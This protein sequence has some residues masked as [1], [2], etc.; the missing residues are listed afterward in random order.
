MANLV[1]PCKD[2]ESRE[3]LGSPSNHCAF[4]PVILRAALDWGQRNLQL[5]DIPLNLYASGLASII[6][7]VAPIFLL[8]T[9]DAIPV[10]CNFNG[11]KGNLACVHSGN[12][13]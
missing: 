12:L 1:Q 7:F 6:N 5:R 11:I 9:F 4:A 3:A 13:V 8:Y 2:T 10:F